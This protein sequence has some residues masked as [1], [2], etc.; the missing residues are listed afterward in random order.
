[1]T[2]EKRLLAG[3]LTAAMLVSLFPLSALA[4]EADAGGLCPHHTEHS[5]E[6]CGYIEAVEGQSCGHVHDG[7]CGYVEAVPEVPCNMGCAETNGDGQIIHSG[8]CAYTPAEVGA[9][10]QHEH[11]GLCGYVEA[12]EG[13]PCDYVCSICSTQ[14]VN[15]LPML[16]AE[17]DVEYRYCDAYGQ[18]W[19]T[20]TK[21][22]GDYT[23][24][25]ADDTAWGG[26]DGQKHWYVASGEVTIGTTAAAQRVRITVTG[27]VHLILED[28]CTL[29][30]NGGINV[31]EGNSL[32][33]YGQ[34]SGTGVLTAQNSGAYN[35]G[36][37]GGGKRGTNGTVTINGG[38]VTANG[39]NLGGAG[40]G[41]GREGSG[42]TVTI[43]GGTV[44]ANGSDG[45]AG[46]GRGQGG[47]GGTVT[48]TGGI[49]KNTHSSG[50][51]FTMTGGTLEGCNIYNNPSSA[52]NAIIKNSTVRNLS[53]WTNNTAE[54][55][56]LNFSN[57]ATL[58]KG[59]TG[60]TYNGS[61]TIAEGA[62][63]TGNTIFNG[64]VTIEKS[65][66]IFPESTIF[67]SDVTVNSD[68]VSF[69]G[70]RTFKN[71]VTISG[72][73]ASFA[74]SM[75]FKGA[76]TIVGDNVS[77]SENTTFSST[78]DIAANKN[79]TLAGSTTLTGNVTIGAGGS[80]TNSGT[81]AVAM[82]CTVSNKGTIT[83]AEG[84]V[85]N[86]SGT[87]ND[88][89]SPKGTITNNGTINLIGVGAVIDSG[90]IGPNLPI[91]D[92]LKPGP[93]GEIVIDLS[94]IATMVMIG[95]DSYAIDG[96]SHA[97]DPAQNSIVLTGAYRGNIS[98]AWGNPAAAVTVL[99]NTMASIILRDV[100]IGWESGSY[101]SSIW[102]KDN[103]TVTVFLE[104]TNT[105]K[106]RDC[107]NGIG[108]MEHT[109]LT[110]E[111]EGTLNLDMSNGDNIVGIGNSRNSG[112][113]FGSITINGGSA[114]LTNSNDS[115]DNIASVLTSDG[116]TAYRIELTGQTNVAS[117]LVDGENQGITANHP[118]DTSLYLYLVHEDAQTETH[119]V[120]VMYQD[121][122]RKEYTATWGGSAFTFDGG[123]T[124]TPDKAS[125][126]SLDV[127]DEKRSFGDAAPLV[128]TVNL[129]TTTRTNTAR[130]WPHACGRQPLRLPDGHPPV[131]RQ[132][133]P[134]SESRP[135]SDNRGV[136][137][138][139]PGVDAGRIQVHRH[140]R[141]RRQYGQLHYHR[142]GNAEHRGPDAGR[143]RAQLAYFRV[144]HLRA[145]SIRADSQRNRHP[146]RRGNSRYIVHQRR[147]GAGSRH[148]ADRRRHLYP[149]QYEVRPLDE[150]GHAHH[151]PQGT[152]RR[153][154]RHHVQ[155]LRR[156]HQRPGWPDHRIDGQS[157]GG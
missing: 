144:R 94:T 60:N 18:N 80:L 97:Y 70:N 106:P 76:V 103:C 100:N 78:V 35:A 25:T 30:I 52:D 135:G 21:A 79:V 50:D 23:A 29:T 156:E 9:P 134:A 42:G 11:D 152:D 131:Q 73:N 27:D 62:A 119:T 112:G 118:E 7:D 24:V 150:N 99:E 8:D 59:D 58:T 88:N 98:G 31:A 14:A 71:T 111:G 92:K 130:Q 127:N 89:N 44:T 154:R 1:M 96:V 4:A 145:E 143:G 148:L 153:H 120:T 51:S 114:K 132:G 45:G 95:P 101:C 68:N 28:N 5:F 15:G 82:D 39:G 128:I 33:I 41:G 90:G 123:T 63:F 86:L 155:A 157:I 138:A 72:D 140:L 108:T 43:N 38:T 93:A 122:S 84:A 124:K 61:V 6:D 121:G 53:S 65:D 10:C 36:I 26:D 77:F 49:L 12:V 129:T 85:I 115:S 56:T 110:V 20:G 19:T 47:G 149:D 125:G 75:T 83:N 113:K 40:I 54:N 126:I 87:I 133:N 141:R 67:N 16:T 55:S 81:L 91:D 46:I 32:T 37:G 137:C 146:G 48:I 17:G 147:H 64:P 2:M 13:Q 66:V 57:P 136:L 69:S 142:R 34:Q 151:R 109:T 22:S 117:V 104:G 3:F 74:D 139:D 107:G 105:L 116:K 102:V